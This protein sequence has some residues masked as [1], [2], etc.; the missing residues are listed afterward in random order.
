MLFSASLQ[1]LVLYNK[2]LFLNFQTL[3]KQPSVSKSIKSDFNGMSTSQEIT[4]IAYI[5][6]FYCYMISS[7]PIEKN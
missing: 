6:I 1:K 4:F 7:I 3:K 2:T 5:Y